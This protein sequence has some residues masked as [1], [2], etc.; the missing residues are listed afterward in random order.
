MFLLTF[1]PTTSHAAATNSC[2][3]S[4]VMLA[5]VGKASRKRRTG[6]YGCFPGSDR[7]RENTAAI[8][9]QDAVLDLGLGRGDRFMRLG[10]FPHVVDA[11]AERS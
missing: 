1:R 6:H 9:R 11:G 2:F 5:G 8:V 7:S 4:A 3:D 10:Q